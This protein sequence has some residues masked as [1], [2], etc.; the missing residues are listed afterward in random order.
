[1]EPIGD[2]L[3]LLSASGGRLQVHRYRLVRPHNVPT[4]QI[5]I[6]DHDDTDLPDPTD[7]DTVV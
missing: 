5:A 6:S 3:P 1:M 2:L 7:R 4:W